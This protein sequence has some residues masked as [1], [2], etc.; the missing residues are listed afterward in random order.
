MRRHH[1]LVAAVLAV[2]GSAAA[3][4]PPNPP[5][6]DALGDPLPDGAVARLG[7]VRLRHPGPVD[8]LRFTPDGRAVVSNG[9]DGDPVVWDV[10][11][12][13]RVEDHGIP[14]PLLTE[15]DVTSA[16]GR[17]VA[18]FSPDRINLELADAA[19]GRLL[20]RVRHDRKRWAAAAITR[21]GKGLLDLDTANA[22]TA[23]DVAT[24]REVG[25][26]EFAF[27]PWPTAAEEN[28]PPALAPDGSL[29]AG[30]LKA[31]AKG[32][33]D[34]TPVRF[35]DPRM[36][37]EYRP[38]I[39][40]KG[41]WKAWRLSADGTRLTAFYWDGGVQL[42]DTS[43]GKQVPNTAG[44]LGGTNLLL[45]PGGR[46]AVGVGYS[47]AWLTDLDTNAT[48]WVTR[49]SPPLA[50]GPGLKLSSAV[51]AAV[52]P[53]GKMI[54]VGTNCGHITLLD[55]ATG[56]PVGF[57]KE[58][59]GFFTGPVQF[60]PDGTSLLVTNGDTLTLWDVVRNRRTRELPG[61]GYD[62]SA[63]PDGAVLAVR[64]YPDGEPPLSV[65]DVKSGRV[66]WTHPHDLRTNGV[67]YSADGRTLALFERDRSVRFV[68]AVTGETRG[69]FRLPADE[70]RS[71]DRRPRSPMAVSPDL[72]RVVYAGGGVFQ[73]WDAA[74]GRKLWTWD[75]GG[76]ATVAAFFLAG[77]KVVA[78][79]TAK[80]VYLLD[81]AT[82][83]ER[84]R[85]GVTD[86]C[87]FSPD[88][89]YVGYL[90][91]VKERTHFEVRDLETDRV[92]V[93]RPRED[94]DSR[95]V[96]SAL[97]PDGRVFACTPGG[98]AVGFFDVRTGKEL[99]PLRRHWAYIHSLAF[100]PDGRS[101]AACYND[102]TV[103]VWEVPRPAP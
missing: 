35:F 14:R 81:A 6:T 63:S 53:D 31:D 11:T 60:L 56:D 97:S 3:A 38:S 45:L 13:K 94:D 51:S 16:D 70:D 57:S 43:T 98:E 79:E 55:A 50:T 42:W 72:G 75:T 71:A 62:V 26:R 44:R 83:E 28:P 65:L 41:W 24:G 89:R 102:S 32:L 15:P 36:G 23:W 96:Q 18:A 87:G 64:G 1:L 100:S 12:G 68:A 39:T 40:L 84:S 58:H 19:T 20:F 73:L 103:V 67:R 10:R 76:G 91:T 33:Q 61:S 78:I 90:A 99:G 22:V 37:T 80:R 92:T 86:P 17:L 95:S 46:R 34:P 29:L 101:L 5:R 82:G 27:G 49:V 8:S 30:V 9:W 2:L 48:A 7:T 52:S 4:A 59:P 93:S 85:V 25:R 74:A 69:T 77:G 66:L 54:A 47:S 88:G 21:D